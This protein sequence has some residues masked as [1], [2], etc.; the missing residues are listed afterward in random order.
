MALKFTIL[1]NKVLVD[2]NITLLKEFADIIE[3]GKSKKDEKIAFD[4]LLYIYYCCDLTSDN[5]FKD[6]DYRLKEE[7]AYAR[8]FGKKKLLAKEK[9]LIESGMDAYNFFNENALERAGLAYDKKIDE[10]RSLLDEVVPEV[11]PVMDESG[12]IDKYVSNDKII[13]SFSKQ[14]N[15][16]AVY[17]LKAM[18]TAKKIENTGRVRGNKGSSLIE[19]GGLRRDKKK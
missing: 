12:E 18:E 3:Y 19:R 7:Q 15:E 14:L 9:A 4:M 13:A 8:I 17:K 16:M 6:V 10:I 2:P 11:H 1:N 5:P